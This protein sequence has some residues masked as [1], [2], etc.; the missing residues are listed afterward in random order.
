MLR[1]SETEERDVS[2]TGV[3]E[4]G[5]SAPNQVRTR[6]VPPGC[7]GTKYQAASAVSQ[8]ANKACSGSRRLKTEGRD[9]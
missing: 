2:E 5:A 8:P 4:I 6:A 3:S 7:D 9:T 1:D